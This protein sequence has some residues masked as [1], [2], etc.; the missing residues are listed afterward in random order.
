[1]NLTKKGLLAAKDYQRLGVTMVRGPRYTHTTSR[2]GSRC[3]VA[4]WERNNWCPQPTATFALP[5]Q[6]G[7]HTI[8]EH[9]WFDGFEWQDLIDRKMAPSIVPVPTRM[10]TRA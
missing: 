10:R 1:M 8:K 9:A 5:T 2:T 6:G 3:V 7:A 4:R